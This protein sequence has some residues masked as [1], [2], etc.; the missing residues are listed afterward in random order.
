MQNAGED[1]IFII[2]ARDEDGNNRSSGRD[3][4]VVEI[5]DKATKEDIPVNIVDNDN[6][7]Y[8]VHYIVDRCTTVTVD[9]MIADHEGTL[10][11]DADGITKHMNGFPTEVS[12]EEPTE[13]TKGLNSLEGQV[14]VN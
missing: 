1:T 6:G 9:I 11:K 14:I 5:K 2:N 8:D 4:W 3:K 13:E 7:N 12:F 10:L